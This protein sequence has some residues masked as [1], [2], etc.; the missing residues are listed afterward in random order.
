LPGSLSVAKSTALRPQPSST[1]VHW[2][3]FVPGLVITAP[4]RRADRQTAQANWVA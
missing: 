3:D 1:I 2:E 4:L